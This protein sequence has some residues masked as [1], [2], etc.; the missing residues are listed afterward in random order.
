M[1]EPL[2]QT[3]QDGAVFSRDQIYTLLARDEAKLAMAILG[4]LVGISSG[5]LV[6]LFRFVLEAPFPLFFD[7]KTSDDFEALPTLLHFVMPVM[8]CLVVG[9]LLHT[10]KPE[11][12][13]LG[14]AHVIDK[15][16]H[17]RSKMPVRNAVMQFVT[18]AIA[19]ISG[20]SCGRE[21]PSIHLGATMGGSIGS[22]LVLPNNSIRTLIAAGS[23]AAIAAAFNTPIAGVIFAMEVILM[24]Y[25]ITGIIP[26]IVAAVSGTVVTQVLYGDEPVF[27]IE[28]VAMNSLWQLPWVVLMGL[29]IGVLASVF[30]KLHKQA[31]SFS[32][33]DIR[34]RL[35]LVGLLTGSVAIFIPEIMG[36]GYDSLNEAML[37]NLGL[38]F[39]LVLL[40]AKLL[41][42]AISLGLGLPGGAIGSSLM[43]GGIAGAFMGTIGELIMPGTISSTAFYVLIGMCAMMG[44]TL[45]APLAA[46]MALLE[47]SDNPAIILPAML[48]IVV[49][50]LT[51]SEGF[52]TRSVFHNTLSLKQS[53]LS[54]ELSRFLNRYGVSTV[55]SFKFSRLEPE[56]DRETIEKQLATNPEWVIIDYPEN[57]KAI[58]SRAA[59]LIA[60]EKESFNLQ[61]MEQV[62]EVIPISM[63][64]T[65]FQALEALTEAK[66]PYG[67]ITMD[68]R[69]GTKSVSGVITQDAIMNFYRGT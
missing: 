24:E 61:D 37:G 64:A 38:E 2:F 41:V 12:Q 28:S 52:R 46:L 39:L 10:L 5:L 60:M 66:T 1:P 36:T 8:G 56:A 26:I 31:L 63:Q 6:N 58:V 25:A 49:S 17:F 16:Q 3:H 20:G 11:Q 50:S 57:N 55:T 18:A 4:I 68:G 43:I 15:V 19:L 7:G 27:M 54:P 44:A 40:V 53:G 29:V 42:T 21:G 33:L 30:V 32:N 45:Q 22:A 35:G 62:T 59:L 69:D 51:S 48:I 23:A 9:L 14:V 47:L 67:Y 34:L 65:L 13:R